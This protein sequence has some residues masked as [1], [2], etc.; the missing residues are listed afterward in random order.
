M[1]I[2]GTPTTSGNDTVNVIAPG[3]HDYIDGYEGT[4][5]MIINWSA[6][7]NDIVWLGGWGTGHR[8]TDD[9]F[10]TV[11]FHN[12]ESVTFQGGSGSDDL[13]TTNGNDELYGNAGDDNLYSGLGADVVDG[14]VGVDRWVVDYSSLLK[15]VVVV[16]PAASATG[17]YTVT[18]T[19]AQIKS[20]ESLS[21]V[22]GANADTVDTTA[23]AKDDS[24][25]TRAGDDTV[26]LGGVLTTPMAVMEPIC[27]S[28][29][30]AAVH[31]TL[32]TPTRNGGVASSKTVQKTR[33]PV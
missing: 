8:F 21:M 6:L 25:E 33:L 4:D 32:C 30:G 19:G 2:T 15:Q 27:W 10:N 29:T 12:F 11:G 23:Y 1:A 9:F 20:I 31:K 22:T 7:T 16:L 24:V 28:S 14:G 5:K 17:Y 13:R 18:A 26:K 3:S